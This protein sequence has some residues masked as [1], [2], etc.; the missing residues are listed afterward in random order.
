MQYKPGEWWEPDLSEKRRK[1]ML[2]LEG[3][4]EKAVHSDVAKFVVVI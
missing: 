4:P 1:K 3:F 2:V